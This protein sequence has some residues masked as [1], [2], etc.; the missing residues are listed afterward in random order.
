MLAEEGIICACEGDATKS[1]SMQMLYELSEKPINITDLLYMDEKKNTILFAHCGSS[2]FAIADRL[3]IAV[4]APILQIEHRSCLSNEQPFFV[5][6][7]K[8]NGIKYAMR[9]DQH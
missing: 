6:I 8:A 1:L 7:A 4:G 5:D 2:G 3:H 9:I